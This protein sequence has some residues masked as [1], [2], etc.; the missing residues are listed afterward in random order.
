MHM[1]DSS[2]LIISVSRWGECHEIKSSGPLEGDGMTSVQERHC[3]INSREIGWSPACSKQLA[4]NK[5]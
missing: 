2:R 5:F 4:K 3:V 1:H